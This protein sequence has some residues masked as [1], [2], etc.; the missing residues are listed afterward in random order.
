MDYLSDEF[1][2]NNTISSPL[3]KYIRF[4]LVYFQTQSKL[5]IVANFY[6]LL[7][8]PNDKTKTHFTDKIISCHILT[9]FCSLLPEFKKNQM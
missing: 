1:R 5:E 7:G 6:T 3:Q 4:C 9:F 2:E 8:S